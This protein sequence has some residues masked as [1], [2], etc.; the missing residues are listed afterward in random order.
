MTQQTI[1][2]NLCCP[3][4]MGCIAIA[5]FLRKGEALEP[6]QQINSGSRQH[7]VLREMNMWINETRQQKLFTMVM[8]GQQF[9]GR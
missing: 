1:Q 7:P 2:K 3:F 8:A 5:A 6:I 9:V 4:G